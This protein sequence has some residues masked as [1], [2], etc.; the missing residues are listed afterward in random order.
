M[1]ME[2]LGVMLVS[3]QKNSGYRLTQ[4]LCVAARQKRMPRGGVGNSESEENGCVLHERGGLQ[5][6]SSGKRK[7]WHALYD[8]PLE[9]LERSRAWLAS[10]RTT[11]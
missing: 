4:S 9:I 11:T 10:S 6:V 3:E 1:A 2:R 7:R 8:H 5:P